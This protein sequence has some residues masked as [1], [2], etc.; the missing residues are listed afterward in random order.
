ME[1]QSGGFQ[2]TAKGAWI[3]LRQRCSNPRVSQW[4]DYG[5]RGIAVRFSSFQEFLAEVGERPP[6]MTIERI[7][8]DGHYEPGNVRWASRSEQARN[9]RNAVFVEIDGKSHRLMDLAKQSGI[10]RDTIAARATQGL[11]MAEV[12]SPERRYNRSG[13]GSGTQVSA[14]KRRALTHCAY[15]HKYTKE[16]T[17]ITPE[18]WRN[19]R[20]CHAAKMRKRYADKK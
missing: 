4:K 7:N 14:A 5:G 19:C 18:G 1:P 13:F 3:G 20:A 11:S 12:L 16:N 17:R 10:K 9:R 6:G 8:N 2:M 15:G